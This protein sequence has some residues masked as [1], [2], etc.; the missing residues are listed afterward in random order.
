M[1]Q[2]DKRKQQI[3]KRRVQIEEAMV[4][5]VKVHGARKVKDRSRALKQEQKINHHNNAVMTSIKNCDGNFC[6]GDLISV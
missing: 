1:S 5:H 2:S 6:I 3:A 4:K